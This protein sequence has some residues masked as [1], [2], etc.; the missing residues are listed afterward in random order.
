MSYRRNPA[1][2]RN[3]NVQNIIIILTIIFRYCITTAAIM[4][5]P[6]IIG[7]CSH[8]I[9]DRVS[10]LYISIRHEQNLKKQ[11]RRMFSTTNIQ[12]SLTVIGPESN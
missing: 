2:G 7:I 5:L 3:I 11:F 8:Q 6:G 9:D 4:L 12:R 1:L 10:I